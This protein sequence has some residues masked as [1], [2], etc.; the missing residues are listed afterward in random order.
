M[1]GKY[2][3]Q[4]HNAVPQPVPESGP[5]DPESSALTIRPPRLPYS[6]KVSYPKTQYPYHPKE[7]HY[8]K[9]HRGERSQKPNFFKEM[10]QNFNFQ[11]GSSVLTKIASMREH[12]I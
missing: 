12:H 5:P 2:L 1:R 6:S 4:E 9:F 11:K 10:K 7:S 8:W 3:A